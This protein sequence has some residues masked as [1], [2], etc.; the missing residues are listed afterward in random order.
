MINNFSSTFKIGIEDRGDVLVCI[1]DWSQGKQRR[2]H[3]PTKGKGFRKVFRRNG[4]KKVFLVDEHRTSLKCN[5]C[6][7]SDF[8]NCLPFKMVQNP[9]PALR[10]AT[11]DG[12]LCLGLLKCQTCRR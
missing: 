9:I 4:F 3:T 1:G 6:K 11:P 10:D 8:G 5:S 7:L 2:H 12:I